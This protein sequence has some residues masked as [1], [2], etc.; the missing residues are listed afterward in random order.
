MKEALAAEG[1]EWVLDLVDVSCVPAFVFAHAEVYDLVLLEDFA[2]VVGDRCVHVFCVVDDTEAWGWVWNFD[3]GF[4]VWVES[5][6]WAEEAFVWYHGVVADSVRPP[7]GMAEGVAWVWFGDC[8]F[9]G[10]SSICDE[11][12][13]DF[14]N[15]SAWVF[16]GILCCPFGGCCPDFKLFLEFIYFLVSDGVCLGP[17]LLLPFCYV[18]FVSG[19]ERFADCGV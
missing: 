19:E 8:F 17:V 14:E 11:M 5:W 6:A 16:V 9:Q 1:I 7:V 10:S 18:S 13:L 3:W 12:A 2:S 15:E 4:W